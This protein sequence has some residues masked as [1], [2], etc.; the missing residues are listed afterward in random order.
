MKPYAKSERHMDTTARRSGVIAAVA[1]I[2]MGVISCGVLGAWLKPSTAAALTASTPHSVQLDE[3][4]A[5]LYQLDPSTNGYVTI[6]LPLN[7]RP[8]S[9]SIVTGTTSDQI[10]F[11]EAGVNRIGRVVYTSTVDYTLSE[12]AVP[13]SPVQIAASAGDVWFTLPATQQVGHLAVVDG[14]VSVVDLAPTTLVD[15]IAVDVNGRAWVTHYTNQQAGVTAIS[16]TLAVQPY[17]LLETTAPGGIAIDPQGNVWVVAESGNVWRLDPPTGDIV[18]PASFGSGN[19]PEQL[20][21]GPDDSLWTSWAD[22]NQLAQ[23]TITVPVSIVSYTIPTANSQPGKLDV[24][25]QGQVYY[26]QQTSN[27]L[28]RLTITPTVSFAD[29]ALPHSNLKL[30]DLA[31]ARDTRVWMVAYHDVRQ[32]YL[33]Q[34]FRAYDS[35]VRVCKRLP[36]NSG[37]DTPPAGIQMYGALSSANGFDRLVES[38]TGLVRVPVIWSNIE[39]ANTSPNAYNWAGLDDS[40][41]AAANANVQVIATIENNPG[42]AAARVSGPVNNLAD[43]QEFVRA[44]V[45]RY[46]C[47]E[48]W[49]FYNEPDEVGRFGLNGAAYAAMLQ[50]VYPVVKTANPN[51]NVLLGGMAMDWFIEDGGPFSRTFLDD[52]LTHC[53][54]QCFDLANFHYY[55]VWRPRW[56]GYGRDII[57]KANYVRQILASHNYSRTVISTETGWAAASWWGSPE[58]QARYVPK[59]FARGMAGGLPITIWYG[60]IDTDSSSPGLLDATMTPRPAFYATQTWV[61]LMRYARYERTIPTSETGAAQIEAYQ[62][63]VPSGAGRKRVDIYWYECPSMNAIQPVDCDNVLPLKIHAASIART[64]KLGLRVV[65][66]DTDDGYRDGYVTL[67]VLSSPIYVDYQP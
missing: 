53:V 39:P 66:N 15:D 31:I 22:A 34:V 38:G 42:W 67:G 40:I 21:L 47:I 35:T 52:V 60:L 5:Y 45:T 58:L 13:G 26:V 19:P 25:T 32:V 4:A 10:W 41:R 49:E 57:G 8:S 7:S 59:G 28:G 36:I 17:S 12:Y 2:L 65:V 18:Q 43:L 30:A 37:S 64:D 1:A 51:A 61:D 55:P 14:V 50:A 29:Y 33:P 3:P 48:N 20:A 6:T 27:H 24:D 11:A 44:A 63:S 56:E 9:I 62:F 16:P 23:L 54:G 46:P